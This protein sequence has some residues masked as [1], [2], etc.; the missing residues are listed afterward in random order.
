MRFLGWNRRQSHRWRG[1]T[2]FLFFLLWF[3]WF[4]NGYHF[5]TLFLLRL[6]R[7]RLVVTFIP[8]LSFRWRTCDSRFVGTES[9]LAA[10]F[11]L[12]T[13]LIT[14]FLF[15][16]RH[17]L[18]E[19]AFT[20]LFLYLLLLVFLDNCTVSTG[21]QTVGTDSFF[22]FCFVWKFAY[23]SS[24]LYFSRRCGIWSR[25]V[26]SCVFLRIFVYFLKILDHK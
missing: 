12:E 16:T 21:V 5:S 22:R 14:D 2:D 20:L 8:S 10:I 25:V 17:K 6:R 19:I 3:W 23:R 4:I 1:K 13:E 15:S 7:L 26:N 11:P 9:F 24:R 18:L